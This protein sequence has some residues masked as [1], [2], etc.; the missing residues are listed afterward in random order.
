M[1]SDQRPTVDAPAYASIYEKTHK[2][3]T[4]SKGT[5]AYTIPDG[6]SGVTSLGNS[7]LRELDG[8]EDLMVNIDI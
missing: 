5:G 4:L 6:V 1:M 3:T 8:S 7:D 2:T